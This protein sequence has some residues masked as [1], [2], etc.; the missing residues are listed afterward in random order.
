MTPLLQIS[1]SGPAYNLR[2][3]VKWI[4]ENYKGNING[5]KKTKFYFLQDYNVNLNLAKELPSGD[6][7]RSSVVWRTTAC[8]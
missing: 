7:L 8:P 6:N 5:I 3:I 1:T 4:K 2:T